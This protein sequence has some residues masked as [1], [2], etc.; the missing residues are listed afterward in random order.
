MEIGFRLVKSLCRAPCAAA[1]PRA[2]NAGWTGIPRGAGPGRGRPTLAVK[3]VEAG[4]EQPA[5]RLDD[6]PEGEG[7][8]GS[9]ETLNVSGQGW[10]VREFS[11]IVGLER[12]DRRPELTHS[13]K[14]FVHQTNGRKHHDDLSSVLSDMAASLLA[15]FATV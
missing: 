3:D 7:A 6:F 14:E 5:S 10:L 9:I 4:V 13:T 12:A 1:D 15:G 2:V 11:A 8:S